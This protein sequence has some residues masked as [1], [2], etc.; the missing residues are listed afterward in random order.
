MF[1]IEILV[2]IYLALEK[3]ENNWY[4]E[5]GI[6]IETKKLNLKNDLIFKTFFSRKGKNKRGMIKIF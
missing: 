2:K 5:G 4:N 3:V 1:L 6:I